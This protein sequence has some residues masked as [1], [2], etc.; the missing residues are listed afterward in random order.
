MTPDPA[1]ASTGTTYNDE[2]L[3]LLT[4]ILSS[5]REQASLRSQYTALLGRATNY[6]S[7]STGERGGEVEREAVAPPPVAQYMYDWAS[8]AEDVLS[9]VGG[10]AV[11]G[12]GGEAVEGLGREI[13]GIHGDI[14]REEE[15][16]GGVEGMVEALSGCIRRVSVALDSI[17]EEEGI[18]NG[19]GSGTVAGPV[20]NGEREAEGTSM[21][22]G[23]PANNAGDSVG[24]KS[25]KKKN[26]RITLNRGVVRPSI[27]AAGAASLEALERGGGD[28]ETEVRVIRAVYVP[29]EINTRRNV[30]SAILGSRRGEAVL[31]FLYYKSKVGGAF[32]KSLVLVWCIGNVMGILGLLKIVPSWVAALGGILTV[33]GVVVNAYFLMLT[34]I[35]AMLL[36]TFDVWYMMYN[37][38]GFIICLC[39]LMPDLR[40]VYLLLTT[41]SGIGAIFADALPAGARRLF[42]L[43]GLGFGL[44]YLVTIQCGLF[45][46]LM[47]VEEFRYEVGWV[48]FTASGAASTFNTNMMVYF[49][50]NITT[51]IFHPKSFTVL[52][53]R[54]RSDKL[55]SIQVKL[56]LA[57]AYTEEV[58]EYMKEKKLSLDRP[59]GRGS[60]G[61]GERD[62]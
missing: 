26:P 20:C 35:V 34:E 62:R 19:G 17:Q 51:A 25:V 58:S 27:L 22:T 12:R 23:T 21:A 45:F 54:L 4:K 47:P 48:N 40:V 5:C 56:M 31:D 7:T 8:H 6:T 18:A 46:K 57:A 1:D 28:N 38:I 55:T 43:I 52:R 2:A 13:E 3:V 60:T 15:R 32:S 30:I 37:W 10:D 36:Q 44:L 11:R 29:R 14:E 16:E 9:S 53:S 42:T 59:R 24:R 50:K 39:L 33:P 49:I 61:E 41:I